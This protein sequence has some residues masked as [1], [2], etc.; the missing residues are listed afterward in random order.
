MFPMW[1]NFFSVYLHS[2]FTASIIFNSLL[3]DLNDRKFLTWYQN[4]LK[5]ASCLSLSIEHHKQLGFH[6]C[7]TKFPLLPMNLF[8]VVVQV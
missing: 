3:E 8:R 4:H 6:I 1:F 2:P 7:S 5:K